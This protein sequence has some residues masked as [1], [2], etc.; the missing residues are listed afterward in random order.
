MRCPKCQFENPENLKF[1]G[2]CG[3]KLE[4]ICSYCNSSNPLQF[5][6]CG[7]CGHDLSLP[8][9]PIPKE[10]SFDEKLAKIQRYLPKDLTQKILAQRD[11]IEGERKQVTVMFCDMEGF[12]TL[13]EKLGSEETY[14][15][16]DQV[17]EILIHKVH[18]YEGTVNELTGDG[19]IALFG[20]PIALED[21]PQRA[22]R[23]ALAIHHEMSKFSDKVKI[24]KRIPPIKMRIGIHT[25]PVVVG[26][27]GND[28][29]VE[30]KAVGDTVNLASRVE[31]LA[32][33]G[34]TYV[35]E[36]TF[37]LAEGLFRFEALGQ[38][39]VKGKEEP[40]DIYRVIAPSTRRT[41]FD[42]SAE[43]GLTPFVG[44]E[45]ELELI[46]D[47]FQRAKTGRGQAF[48]VMAEAGV[49]KSRLLY[50]F[51]K[52]VTNEDVTFLE[53]RCLSYG[54]GVAYH[55]VID[56]LKASFDI[57]EGDGDSE[58]KEKVKG[59]LKVIGVDEATTLPYL[60]ELL[61]VKESGL[62]KIPVSPEAKRDRIMEAIKRITLKGSEIRPV[63]LAYEDLH[64]IDKSSEDYLK[65]L[66][67]SIPGARILLIFTY[68]PEFVHT[69][70]GKS[71]HSQITLNRLSNREG[72]MMISHLLGTE[73]IDSHLEELIVEKTEGVPFFIEEFIRSLRDLKIIER[74][75]NKYYLAKDTQDVTIPSTIHDVI[76]A[77][78]DTL[79]EAAKAVL[80]TGSVAGREF[81]H[82]LI[83]RV[84]GLP[85]QELLTHLS[86]LKDSELLY[87]R[88]VYP[89]STYIFKHSLT[90]DA[91][92]QSLLKST[93]Q[94]YHRKIAEVLEKNFPEMVETQ[95]E[96]LAHHYTEA[97][98]NEQAVGYWHQAGKHAT[99]RYANVEATHYLTKALE[100]LM[101]LPDTLERAR[102]ELDVQITLGAVLMAVKGFASLDTERAYARSR[103]LCQRLG[104]TSQLFP[105]LC[106]LWRF[107]MNRAEL[108]TARE[109]AEQLFSLAQRVQD[110][111]FLLEAHR[112][113]G[114]TMFWV[115]EM[116]PARAHLEQGTALYDP[117]K[118]R[119][120]AFVYGQDPGV[121]CRSFA[122]WPIWVLGYPDQA[123]RSANEALTL[124]QE[125]THPFSL[126]FALIMATVVP[127]FRRE[128]EAVRERAQALIT[129]STE[130]GF[131]QWLAYGTILRGWTLTAQGEGADGIAQIHQGLV[132]HPALGSEIQRPYFLSLLAEAYGKVGQPEE[133]L[134]VLVEALALVGACH[135]EAELHRRKGELLLMQQG[136]NV[137]EAEEC[138]RQALDIAR[139]QQAK[140]LE[141]RAA[142]SLSRLW[143]Q[144]GK[145]EEARQLLTEIYA[146]FTEGF[147]TADLKEAKFLLEE[148]A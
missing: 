131:P 59:G 37:R 126:A 80:Q 38:K 30:F 25:G 137:G 71:F 12:T 88:G 84:T 51:R 100:V 15:L 6:F 29:R 92:Y 112:V 58:I 85:E 108:Q 99:Q 104:E 91:T 102:Q 31:S 122:A 40:V 63:I 130:Q 19:I 87:E 14:A 4:K 54:K 96:L 134:T 77:R 129:L 114:Q 75:G 70:G 26:T 27:L 57:H 50:E 119:S 83:R 47:G 117:Q 103:E 116:A 105:V 128:V 97:G 82:D 76:M 101:T 146:W 133:G 28:L 68:R 3:A 93:R 145:Q 35:T 135:W 43:R 21:A 111:A 22:I 141:L 143:Q 140:S 127:Q 7:E 11:K 24:E 64:W 32:V 46:L 107:Y 109:L 1:C 9:R 52:A 148:L 95:P 106:G 72:L 20:A 65:H 115:G 13:T 2:E 48:S 5:K 56:I 94:K 49:G 60:L 90:Q 62:D 79:P 74:R 124:A 23:S 123:L 39:K 67:E 17:Y 18:D 69:W 45:R 121:A 8:S 55:P 44:R 33:P 120:H 36:E 10:L 86:V 138:F 78:V 66:L 42:V 144:Q 34:G 142:M 81:S 53:G 125:L 61:Y 139:G 73:E 136:Q 147:D 118:H 16:M 132:A 110:T 41:R 98:L 89:Q 113:M